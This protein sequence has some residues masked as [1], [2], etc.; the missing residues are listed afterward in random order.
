MK[1]AHKVG[2]SFTVPMAASVAFGIWLWSV[3]DSVDDAA[4]HVRDESVASAM[5]AKDMAKDVVQVQQF[6]SDI[7]ATRGQDGLD[8]GLELAREHHDSF[9]AALDTFARWAEAENDRAGLTTLRELKERFA[10]YYQT[11]TSMARAYIDGGPAA[12]NRL[13]AEFD[14]ASEAL[15]EALEPF[16]T[17]H[18]E[19]TR[20]ALDRTEH[21]VDS[22]KTSSLLLNLVSMLFSLTVAVAIIRA[23]DRP[24]RR[25]QEAVTQ[26]G[27][28][29]MTVRVGYAGRD[30]IGEM[31]VHLDHTLGQVGEA[32]RKVSAIADQVAVNAE[33]LATSTHQ[34]GESSRVQAQSMV[35]ISGAV[36]QITGS[37]DAVS[38]R[39]QESNRLSAQTSELVAHGD[40]AIGVAVGEMSRT[41]GLLSE[42]ASRVVTLS[43]RSSEIGRI[44]DVIHGIADQTNLLA[45]NA[46]I[47]AARAGEAGRGFAVVA[48]E[49]RRLAEHTSSATAEIGGLIQAIQRETADAVKGMDLSREQMDRG[50]KL[51]DEAGAVFARISDSTKGA[52][53]QAR[54]IAAAI[55]E[56]SCVGAGIVDHV[57]RIAQIGEE[58]SAATGVVSDSASHLAE[59][60]EQLQRAVAR[61]RV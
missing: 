35:E 51:A 55:Q 37:I 41:A 43:E 28:G 36:E 32:V 9:V 60:A 23:I 12:G 45:L 3:L 47:E 46:A 16:V 1:I 26:V 11:G 50:V 33:Q 21:L 44:I 25:M 7:S 17:A 14:A 24:L 59:L 48:D 34:L 57:H 5:L 61:F 29:D 30:E 49:V 58:N 20:A 13:M 10:R 19:E 56:Q 39:T 6:L 54:D 15:Q 42:S 52:L 40:H 53:E 31:A 8:D 4:R 27:E 18:I 22:V 38:A 2:I